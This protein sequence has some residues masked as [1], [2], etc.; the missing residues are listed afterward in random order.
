MCSVAPLL[1]AHVRHCIGIVAA[2][3]ERKGVRGHKVCGVS[4][5]FLH[6][7]LVIQSKEAYEASIS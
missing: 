3:L 2:I 7:Q 6:E 4:L 1:I 5:G